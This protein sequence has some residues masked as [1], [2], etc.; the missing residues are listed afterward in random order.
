LNFSDLLIILAVQFYGMVFWQWVLWISLFLVFYNYAGYAIIVLIANKFGKRGPD[1]V[2]GGDVKA[3]ASGPDLSFAAGHLPEYSPAVSFIVAA[4]NEE[5]C[6]AEKIANSLRQD[7]PSEKIE[8]IFITDGSV[9]KTMDIIRGY[10]SVRLMHQP[11]RRGKSAAI[12]RA[13]AAA[14]HDLL[15]F[16]DANTLLNKE[17]TRR[18]VAHYRHSAVGGVAGE[19]KVNSSTEGAQEVGAGEGLYWKYESFLKRSDARFYSVVG[20][21]GELFSLRKNLYEALPDNVILDDFVLSLKVTVKGY[22]VEYEPEAYAI[23]LPS[24]SLGDEQ[25]RKVRIA[26]G[27][28]QA[29]GMLP[30]LLAFWRQPRLSF[31]YISHRVLRW[32][33]SPLGLILAF[34]SNA[35]I[36]FH[37]IGGS[38]A[39]AAYGTYFAPATAGHF[40]LL[41]F[42]AQ[43]LFYGMAAAGALSPA[44]MKRFKLLKLAYYFVFMN[45]SVI[46]GFFRFLRGR[47]A[48]T[49]EKARRVSA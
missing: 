20:A 14:S 11:E 47:Q 29:I 49:W 25:K 41:L 30:S 27:G 33:L 19:K 48:A 1:A 37:G 13:V 26:A 34:V 45:I 44:L 23:E 4:Y 36:C 40:F 22:R 39:P 5:D 24:F 16:S 28:F 12:N 7:Y 38:S 2:P 9:D 32:T 17:A 3:A 8:F 21:A 18:I 31:L 42:L 35:V 6:V 15:I 46:L 10:P 43:L